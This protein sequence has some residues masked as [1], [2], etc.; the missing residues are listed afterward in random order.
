M[1]LKSLALSVPG[2]IAIEILGGGCELLVN[3]KYEIGGRMGRGWNRS[4]EC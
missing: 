3:R 1:N 2:I 4:K